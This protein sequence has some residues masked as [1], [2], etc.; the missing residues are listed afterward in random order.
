[1][2][3]SRPRPEP[4]GPI[5]TEDMPPS[6]RRREVA[7]ILARG[8]LRLRRITRIGVHLHAQKSQDLRENRLELSSETRLSVSQGTRGL[9]LRDDGDDV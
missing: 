6:E 4:S 3:R 8:V 1:M 7:A 9:R 2:P 5:G